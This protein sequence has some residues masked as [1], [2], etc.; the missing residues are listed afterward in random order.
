MSENELALINRIREIGD[1]EAALNIAITILESLLAAEY[2]G[3]P[4][5]GCL[6]V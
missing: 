4:T 3:L 2:G 1:S 5:G 6:V